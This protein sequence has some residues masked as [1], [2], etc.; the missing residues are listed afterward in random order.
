MGTKNDSPLNVTFQFSNKEF[1]GI[2]EVENC[3]FPKLSIKK[4]EG[5]FPKILE[6]LVCETED[7]TYTLLDCTIVD[8]QKIYPDYVIEG[9]FNGSC[10]GFEI[11]LNDF[12]EWMPGN[13]SW[14]LDDTEIK[15]D[16]RLK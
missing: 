16:V 7:E 11:I 9:T 10:D 14:T 4:G 6:K 2:L 13:S 15:K 5:H 8:G 1:E 3:D 12:S